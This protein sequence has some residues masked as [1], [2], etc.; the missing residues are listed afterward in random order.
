MV[1]PTHGSAIGKLLDNSPLT[2]EKRLKIARHV[3]QIRGDYGRP[4]FP[5]RPAALAL[6]D[7][8]VIDAY[9][10]WESGA[11]PGADKRRALKL[12]GAW[13]QAVRQVE[14]HAGMSLLCLVDAAHTFE[15]Q[16]LGD[17]ADVLL[18]IAEEEYPG[19]K[20][21]ECPDLPWDQLREWCLKKGRD[22][23]LLPVYMR[24]MPSPRAGTPFHKPQGQ[25]GEAPQVDE[26]LEEQKSLWDD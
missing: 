6:E 21:S 24:S 12:F 2:P 9:Q 17:E 25:R 13:R 3:M 10:I 20:R 5:D 14:A 7:Y 23:A 11:Q 26:P 8:E 19:F 4:D 16:H 22:Y 18:T 15:A 1:M